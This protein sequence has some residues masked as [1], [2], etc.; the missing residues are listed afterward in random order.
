MAEPYGPVTADDPLGFRITALLLRLGKMT[1]VAGVFWFGVWW[2]VGLFG[3][4]ACTAPQP[5]PEN[6]RTFHIIASMGRRGTCDGYVKPWVGHTYHFVETIGLV[7]L[8]GF[9]AL[10]IAL[11]IARKIFGEKPEGPDL[12]A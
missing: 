5:Q 11:T 4:T 10:A 8:I 6:G 2:V 9:F 3:M 1:G 12:R 7:L